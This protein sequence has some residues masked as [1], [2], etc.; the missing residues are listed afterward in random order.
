[1]QY[2][3]RCCCCKKR[4]DRQR[5]R[6][7]ERASKKTVRCYG[8]FNFAAAAP[9]TVSASCSLNLGADPIPMQQSLGQRQH[10][11]CITTY[12]CRCRLQQSQPAA[13]TAATTATIGEKE[14]AR[15]LFVAAAGAAPTEIWISILAKSH[16]EEQQLDCARVQLLANDGSG[17]VI[18]Q[19]QLTMHSAAAAAAPNDKRRL[20]GVA[21]PHRVAILVWFVFV[22][23][24][25]S[26]L[27]MFCRRVRRRCWPSFVAAPFSWLNAALFL[28]LCIRFVFLLCAVA[29]I[30]K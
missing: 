26:A 21:S 8:P 15:L 20:C 18:A 28:L 22:G 19:F 5:E 2:D 12:C 9:D 30:I 24:L 27:M 4:L 16:T 10:K 3:W 11:N 13:A 1:M 6:A 17:R 7:S 23:N 14:K 25:S 29:I